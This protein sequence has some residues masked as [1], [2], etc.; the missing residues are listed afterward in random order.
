LIERRKLRPFAPG[1]HGIDLEVFL[2][3]IA[4]LLGALAAPEPVAELRVPRL[5]VYPI[6]R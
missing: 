5:V 2:A 4:A 3:E 6:N 1:A